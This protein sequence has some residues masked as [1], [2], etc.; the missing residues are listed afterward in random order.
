MNNGMVKR[1]D[2]SGE[3]QNHKRRNAGLILFQKRTYM[4]A[5]KKKIIH[6]ASFVSGGGE[7]FIS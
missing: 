7:K 3:K 4:G 6:A 5:K 1:T 2:I